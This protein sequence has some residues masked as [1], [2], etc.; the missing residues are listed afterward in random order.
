MPLRGIATASM[1]AL[2]SLLAV[3]GCGSNSGKHGHHESVAST[4]AQRADR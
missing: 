3:G 4:A 1:F 2:A